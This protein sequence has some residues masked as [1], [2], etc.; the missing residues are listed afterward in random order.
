MYPDGRPYATPI[1]Y[2]VLDGRIFFHGRKQGDKVS[3]IENDPR[4]SLAVMQFD[5]FE[6]TGDMSCNTTTVYRSV[7][8]QGKVV[9]IED[10]EQ[11]D[12]VLR[13]VVD[14][15][16]PMRS[17]DPFNPKAVEASGVFEIIPDEVTGKYHSMAPENRML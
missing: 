13:A 11:K 7:I 4:C 14:K 10:P 5:G 3:N 6:R 9:K 17:G 16:T 8:V 12:K 1:H 15:L 2:I